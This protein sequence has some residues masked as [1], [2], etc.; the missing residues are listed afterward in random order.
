MRF[1]WKSPLEVSKRLCPVCGAELKPIASLGAATTPQYFYCERC[2]YK[3]V[4]YIELHNESN[5]TDK[6]G[7]E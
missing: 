7:S 3:G 5:G 4:V 1:S 6:E 2:G